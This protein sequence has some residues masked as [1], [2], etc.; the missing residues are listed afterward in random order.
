MQLLILTFAACFEMA[1][2]VV[3]HISI[4]IMMIFHSDHRIV[5]KLKID[6]FLTHVC[7]HRGCYELYQKLGYGGES[8]F[9]PV[10]EFSR[11]S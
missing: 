8:C 3:L 1:S 2:R 6:F 11:L 10:S 4:E 7:A 9:L 5:C